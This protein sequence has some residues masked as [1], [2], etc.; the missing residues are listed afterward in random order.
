MTDVAEAEGRTVH[1]AVVVLGLIL[2]LLVVD[3]LSD[4]GEHVGAVHLVV[5]GVALVLSA[6][7]VGVLVLRLRRVDREQRRLAG[8]L[9]ASE[10]EA[11]HWRH[12]AADA[13]AGLREALQRQF[14][15]WELTEA[16]RQV[17]ILLLQ[18]LS[19]KQI[20]GHRG[21]SER[22]VRQQ[23]HV[24]YRK[25][26][27]AGRADLAAFFLQDLRPAGDDGEWPS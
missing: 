1:F 26:G 22:T 2:A 25:A 20:A 9:A 8:R 4:A 3:L 14:D 5:E 10:S 23:A 24:L 17:A 13:V 19:H 21:A 16:E 18:G 7:G 6:F 11:E 15:R 27:L 12:E